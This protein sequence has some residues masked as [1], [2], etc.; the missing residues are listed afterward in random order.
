M[1]TISKLESRSMKLA[2]VAGAM[3]VIITA[4][5]FVAARFS[6]REHLT[7][8]DIA[9]LR[10]AGASVVFLPIIW[11][12]GLAKLKILGLRRAAI[13]TLLVGL[14]YPLLINWGLSYAPAAHAAAICPASIV[15]FS[16][17]LS[18]IVFKDRVSNLRLVG[19]ATIMVGLLI[20]VFH[21][22][23]GTV[24]TLFGD[25]LFAGSG[26]MFSAYAVLVRRWA[27]D[28]VTATAA[29]VLLSCLLVPLLAIYARS[30]LSAASASEIG[31]QIVIQG[32][33]AGAAAMFLYTYAVSHLGPQIASLFMPC[34]PIATA[35]TGMMVLGEVPASA[36]FLAIA[37][38]TAGMILPALQRS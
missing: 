24:E 14:P 38:M 29:I 33:L 23:T 36:Q 16:F 21:Q 12:T 8:A 3:M 10:Y 25:L 6:L 37:I 19:I 1:P 2:L 32:F 26:V 31:A 5:Q 30:G 22:E 20:F 11:M 17:A 13:L 9:I 35:V 18:R 34:V 28:P 27:V 15:F 4:I 7:A